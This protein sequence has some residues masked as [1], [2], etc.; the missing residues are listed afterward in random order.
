MAQ[1]DFKEGLE[2]AGERIVEKMIDSLFEQQAVV[3]GNLANSIEYKVDEPK[4]G[5]YSM[6]I[7]MLTYG[8][9][10]DEGSERG[11]GKPPP[12]KAI[13]DWI[14]RKG[15]KPPAGM[16]T[17]TFAFVIARS[18]GKN[19]QKFKQPKPFITPS[20]EFVANSYLPEVLEDSGIKF[21]EKE[22]EKISD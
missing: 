14:K 13:A 1:D 8:T 9:Y 2:L 20:V 19:G 3:T 5:K 21:I 7:S 12:V 18:I 15:I 6:S 22:L 10:V 17:K 11:P 4:P 16:S